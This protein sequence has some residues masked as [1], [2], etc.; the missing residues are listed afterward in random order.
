MLTKLLKRVYDLLALHRIEGP[1]MAM[2]IAARSK[3]HLRKMHG[4]LSENR[5]LAREDY[6]ELE[7]V[8]DELYPNGYE[9]G[10]DENILASI[11]EE[12]CNQ[13]RVRYGR[14]NLTA[15]YLE[16]LEQRQEKVTVPVAI[17]IQSTVFPCPQR[18]GHGDEHFTATLFGQEFRV[19]FKL[20]EDGQHIVMRF[21]IWEYDLTE[22]LVHALLTKL[23]K[24]QISSRN[25]S[26]SW[27]G[28][29]VGL[30]YIF[31]REG[32]QEHLVL[33]DGEGEGVTV[34][35]ECHIARPGFITEV[36]RRLREMGVPIETIEPIM[37]AERRD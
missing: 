22:P 36:V 35:G 23:P 20:A 21:M 18:K 29:G 32:L 37:V 6:L 19:G 27:G 26:S 4:A 14:G 7:A 2:L 28:Q 25:S 34:G 11:L 13:K 12:L 15:Y 16:R 30:Y 3:G 33:E 17:G 1:Y 5:Q 8:W 31:D 9:N 10:A 24:F